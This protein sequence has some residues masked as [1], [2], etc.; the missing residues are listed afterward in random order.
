[1][2]VSLFIPCFVDQLTP[3]VGMASAQVLKRLG[4]EVEFRDA[5][6]CCGQPS[7][8]SGHWD[9][10]RTAALR[11]L[12]VF[13]G[14]EIV[15]GPSASCVAM[16]KKFYPEILVGHPRL[17]EAQDLAARTFEFGEFLVRKL[18]VTD[19]GAA[20][21]GK[22]TYH[23]GCHALRELGLKEE[24]RQLLRAVKGLTLLE[25]EEAETCCGFGGMFSVKFP[26][27]STAMAQ[28]KCDALVRSG[29][30]IIVS[31]DPSCL[32]QIG[33]Y[34]TREGKAIRTLHLSEVLANG[35]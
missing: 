7:F 4:H 17:Q 3:R 2:R 18:G 8:N 30:D 21:A 27:I 1:M 34:L 26:M 13:K 32:L 16:M 5:Q 31:S 35:S 24:P 9:V 25:S 14:A 11:A 19:V 33:G 10:A 23:D 6:T 12:D 29:A 22:A 20:F 28:V 15:V